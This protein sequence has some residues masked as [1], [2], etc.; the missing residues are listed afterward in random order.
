MGLCSL[1]GISSNA[2]RV[3]ILEC[4]CQ[5]RGVPPRHRVA[6]ERRTLSEGL[7]TATAGQVASFTGHFLASPQVGSNWSRTSRGECLG[8]LVVRR[9]T[10]RFQR[11]SP[12]TTRLQTRTTDD[13]EQPR[14]TRDLKVLARS[15]DSFQGFKKGCRISQKFGFSLVKIRETMRT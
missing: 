14:G 8:D 7:G 13:G 9:I 10:L 2:S 3:K 15:R 6:A 1:G 11:R 12:G 5:N 4:I